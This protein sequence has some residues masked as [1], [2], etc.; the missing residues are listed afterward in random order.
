MNPHIPL[1]DQLADHEADML[2]MRWQIR[3]L[4]RSSEERRRRITK[5]LCEIERRAAAEAIERL[6]RGIG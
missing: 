2:R 1:A 3:A 5:T 4:K 6:Q